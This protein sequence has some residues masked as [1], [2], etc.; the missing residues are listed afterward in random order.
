MNSANISA[1]ISYRIQQAEESLAAAR[2]MFENE[3]YQSALNMRY[4]GRP[5]IFPDLSIRTI[6][7]YLCWLILHHVTKPHTILSAM[8]RCMAPG[9]SI[10]DCLGMA[11]PRYSL[12]FMQIWKYERP[13]ALFI[14][15]TIQNAFRSVRKQHYL[16]Q[17]YILAANQIRCDI[18]DAPSSR[19]S[20]CGLDEWHQALLPP[21]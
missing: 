14:F 2:L 5:F 1:L 9:L 3:L 10:I 4:E 18:H 11:L 7:G 16:L 19:Q 21:Q 12:I 6:P 17:P 8:M 15:E 13:G 20:A